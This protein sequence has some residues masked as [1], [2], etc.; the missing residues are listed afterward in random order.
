MTK[1]NFRKRRR[2]LDSEKIELLPADVFPEDAILYE[3]EGRRISN[4]LLEFASPLITSIDTG[5]IFQFRLMLYF[6][7]VAWNFSYFKEGKERT[8]ALDRFI[9]NNEMF[10]DDKRKQMHTIVNSFAVRKHKM[11]WQY[12]F[13][14]LNFEVI[15]G[16]K[17]STVMA[18]AIPYSLMDMGSFLGNVH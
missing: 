8:E 15:K 13:M 3:F 1:G 7:A 10:T 18:S 6:S 4:I 14:L 2:E 12:D 16:E 9:L 5:N 17:N 11:F